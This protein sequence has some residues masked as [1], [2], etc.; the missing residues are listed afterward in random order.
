[1]Y[2]SK[3]SQQDEYLLSRLLDGDLPADQADGLHRRMASEPELRAAYQE[4]GRLDQLLS[5]RRDDQPNVDWNR[6]RREVMDRVESEAPTG[7]SVIRFPGWLRIAAPLAAA[8]SVVLVLT[9]YPIMTGGPAE[10]DPVTPGR[11][12][13]TV[14][15]PQEQQAEAEDAMPA[16]TFNRQQPVEQEGAEPDVLASANR[17]M[18]ETG[19]IEVKYQQSQELA[20]AIEQA[21]RMRENAPSMRRFRASLKNQEQA[22]QSVPDDIFLESPSL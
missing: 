2:E 15:T 13:V 9:L 20:E 1:M 21:D 8:A 6:F 18:E 17:K 7:G 12:T 11:V 5:A 22:P 10:K 3:I 4:M 14:H 16:V 19:G